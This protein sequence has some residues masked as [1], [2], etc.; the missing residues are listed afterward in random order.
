MEVIVAEHA[1]FCFGVTKA[2]ETVY[3]QIKNSSDVNIYTYGPIIHNE[4]VVSD[5]EKKGVKGLIVPD[6][7]ECDRSYNEGNVAYHRRTGLHELTP[8]DWQR[9]M[10]FFR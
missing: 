1:G 8:W 7:I 10:D 9:V 5:L 3:D 6:K 2:V 4:I